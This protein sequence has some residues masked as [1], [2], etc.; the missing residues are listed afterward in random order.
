M[1][2][3][4]YIM[5]CCLRLQPQVCNSRVI[6]VVQHFWRTFYYKL[7]VKINICHIKI[8]WSVPGAFSFKIGMIQMDTSVCFEMFE[9]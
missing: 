1:I 2:L 4:P 6:D 8:F 3:Y 5:L 9:I 7:H